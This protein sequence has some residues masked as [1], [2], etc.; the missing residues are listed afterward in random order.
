MTAA[1]SMGPGSVSVV[2]PVWNEESRNLEELVER[3][4]RVLD[5][6]AEPWEL[7]LVDDGSSSTSTQ[8]AL[9][10]IAARE[11]RIRLVRL[12]RH[13]GQETALVVGLLAATGRLLCTID[14]DLQNQP[15]DLPRVIALLNE[16]YDL[17]L[18]RRRPPAGRRTMRCRLSRAYTTIMNLRWGVALGDW[19]CGL[20][21]CRRQVWE[22]MG[23]SSRRWLW[24]PLKQGAIR[25]AR[26]SV[27][28]D[29]AWAPRQRGRSGYS[30][31]RSVGCAMSMVVRGTSLTIQT[32]HLDGLARVPEAAPGPSNA[33]DRVL[34]DE[35]DD[36]SRDTSWSEVGYTV[37]P[38]LAPQEYQ[39]LRDGIETLVFTTLRRVG[40][41]VAEATHLEAYHSLI[42]AREALHQA[43]VARL[44]KCPLAWLPVPPQRLA[45]RVG[46]ICGVRLTT[47]NPY[48]GILGRFASRFGV[49]IVRPHSTD[50]N[51]LH[52]D[53][54]LTRLRHAINIYVPLAG[55][56]SASS[57]PVVPGSHRWR[58]SDVQRTGRGAVVNGRT[59]T[60]P[61]LTGCRRA[62]APIRPDPSPNEVLVFSP[63]LLHGG[64]VNLNP[65]AT[66][67]SL[68]MRF[69][70]AGA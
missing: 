63:Y 29:V 57:L 22:G 27:E 24:G 17:V 8:H 69:W 64:A 18:G 30:L 26:R 66:R 34:L 16:G 6:V 13:F 51:P 1:G 14:C 21:G 70:R 50:H 10:A 32:L 58:E 60:V 55:S 2:T 15:E 20:N 33:E 39:A 49:R 31:W 44:G 11:A 59:Y 25:Q 7:V 38:F 62:L 48:Y 19:G 40:I 67:V 28:L 43:V 45:Q 54:W 36:L 41:V 9:Q 53:V 56:T 68:E 61:S 47:S 35:D 5:R 65:D 3:L 37:A 42:G 12:R 4:S 46:E 52:R 23:T